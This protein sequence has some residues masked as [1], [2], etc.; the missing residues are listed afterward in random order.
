MSIAHAEII[1]AERASYGEFVD[2]VGGLATIVL[3]IAGL[4]GIAPNTMLGIGT[5]I[6]GAALLIQGAAI[7]AEYARVVFSAGTTAASIDMF[8]G[9][10]LS[11]IFLVGAGGVVLG[12]L[13]LIGVRPPTLTAVAFIAFGAGMVTNSRSVLK[14]HMIRVSAKPPSEPARVGSNILTAGMVSGSA[15]IQAFAGLSAVVL[16]ILAVVGMR[17]DGLNLIALLVLGAT[18]M[19]TET[20]FSD[21]V[22]SFM[23]PMAANRS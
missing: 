3:T 10:A 20:A 4:T 23:R 11:A 19:L 22:L 2:A 7:L 18:L 21:A 8:G 9:G 15:G 14:V 12:V 16:G 5:I 6:F 1:S 17:S 13:A